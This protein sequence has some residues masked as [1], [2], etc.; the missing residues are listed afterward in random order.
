MYYRLHL[1]MAILQIGI[2]AYLLFRVLPRIIFPDAHGS[3]P[4]DSAIRYWLIMGGFLVLS[5]FVLTILK[6]Y[7]II[8]LLFLLFSVPVLRRIWSY[9]RKWGKWS[10]S[11]WIRR[12]A[13]KA[14]YL[15]DKGIN[16]HIISR[17]F[18]RAI[19]NEWKKTGF[20]TLVAL[21]VAI[22]ALIIRIVPA[23]LHAAPF[24]RVWFDDL[25]H[26][27][28][29]LQHHYFIGEPAPGGVYS[30][31]S[32]F[33]YSARIS[34]E[35]LLH[36]FGALTI[37][38][39]CLEIYWAL[40]YITESNS[41]ALFGMLLFALFPTTI[42]PQLL[43]TQVEANSLLLAI[44]FALPTLILLFR[45]IQ[46]HDE[47]LL[48]LTM[49]VVATGFTN[50]F[51]LVEFLLPI[52]LI[53]LIYAVIRI[54]RR[55]IKTA[56]ILIGMAVATQIPFIVASLIKGYSLNY[57]LLSQL[58]STQSIGIYDQ[59]LLPLTRLSLIYSLAAAIYIILA[60][61][62]KLILSRKSKVQPGQSLLTKNLLAVIT[63]V[64][65]LVYVASWSTLS[66]WIDL[67]Q[68]APV[69][70]VMIAI[71]GG[72]IMGWIVSI[73]RSATKG[74]RRLT[75]GTGYL[76]G[77]AMAGL[78]LLFQ[79]GIRFSTML[80]KT[81]PDGFY[82]AF[83]RIINNHLPYTYAI[84]APPIDKVQSDNRSYFMGYNYFLQNYGKMDSLYEAHKHAR[85]LP[86][87]DPSSQ[88]TL[89]A[90]IFLMIEKPDSKII[91]RGILDDQTKVMR[92]MSWWLKSYRQKPG[93]TVH[94]YYHDKEVEV[95]ELVNDPGA[96]DITDVL[97]H[98][99][100]E[101]L[102]K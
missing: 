37:A 8:S 23:Y 35:L 72:L 70:S 5:V 15:A 10:A 90:S 101:K 45:R 50:T 27:K 84:V 31:I 69:Y 39:L 21:I 52:F 32:V 97:W 13:M 14:V 4:L 49:G 78:L 57:Y 16:R 53:I 38:L 12:V 6:L 22:G 95:V 2:C 98:V 56:L 11:N 44:C 51:I 1:I 58:F 67:D 46:D 66:G 87:F 3:T 47:S 81:Q 86:A 43:E 80:P 64:I 19:V 28:G 79:G 9:R 20:P 62:Q 75:E 88:I 83:Y 82:E 102:V 54:N 94:T 34:P 68:L 30:L 7:D 63:A 91:Q 99:K 77:A 65:A 92:E 61:T 100:P 24:S 33:S 96:S 42:M 48:P 25:T 60:T 73:V 85:V 71:L 59:L 76:L 18:Y 29:L 17:R 26:V 89:P 41:A 40:S 55:D 74:N 93:R 36:I